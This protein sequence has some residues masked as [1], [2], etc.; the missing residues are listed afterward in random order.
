MIEDRIDMSKISDD[1]ETDPNDT[2]GEPMRKCP[3]GDVFIRVPQL[4]AIIF[5]ESSRELCCQ[6]FVFDAVWGWMEG[7]R[8][9]INETK[10]NNKHI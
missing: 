7:K 9:T 6:L 3:W 8:E 5:C 1:V 4:S 2:P 10:C